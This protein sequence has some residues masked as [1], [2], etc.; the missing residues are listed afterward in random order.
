LWQAN[1]HAF[2]ADLPGALHLYRRA[3]AEAGELDRI[4]AE[5]KVWLAIAVVRMIDDLSSAAG[6]AKVASALIASLGEA[7][8]LPE[9]LLTQAL[10]EVLRGRPEAV[11]LMER[12][13][14]LAEATGEPSPGASSFLRALRGSGFLTAVLLMFF[15]RLEEARV[16]LEAVHERALELGDESSLPVALR[17]LAFV[18][19][20][21][22]DWAT[23]LR[24]SE[25]GYAIAVQVSQP[26][27]QASLAGMR[28][29]VLA[30]LGRVE[31]ARGAADESLRLSGQTG[32]KLAEVLSCSALGLLELSLG[33]AAGAHDA[34]GPLVARFEA[35]G[36]REPGAGRFLPNEIEA[37]IAI[38]RLDEAEALLRKLERRARVL[39]RPSALA[40]SARCRG[41]LRSARD[42][43]GRAL[44]SFASALVAHERVPMPFERARTLL[45]LG[46]TERRARRRLAARASLEEALASFEEL[47]AVLWARQ[48]RVELDRIGG[49]LRSVGLT[50]TEQRIAELVAEGRPNKEVAAVLHLTPKTVETALTRIYRKLGIHSRTALA[51]GLAEGRGADDAGAD[52]VTK[53]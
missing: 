4:R 26:S 14:G 8:E 36:V 40:A 3:I 39:D 12:A 30:H 35:A 25:E 15:D 16:G 11:E 42:D 7:K 48:A 23:A 33:D 9:Y 6:H 44:D 18:A 38:G 37:L 19:W 10:V 45:A 50:P 2:G 52:A 27:L 49:R 22:G 20:L 34:L 43:H 41:L 21:E 53:L 46:V 29:L 17:F 51:R 32:T 24:Q 13:S 47:G 31:E 5:A 1:V 28:A